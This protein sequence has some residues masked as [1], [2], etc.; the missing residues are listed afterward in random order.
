MPKKYFPSHDG[1][2]APLRLQVKGKVRFEEVDAV[3][4]VWHG[5]YSTYFEDARTVLGDKYGVGYMDFLRNET[6]V[7][8]KRLHIDYSIPLVYKE[9]MTIEA[10]MHWSEA[11][12]INYEF[13][14]KNSEG[15]VTTTGYTIQMM[16]DPNKK[17]R[18][19]PPPFYKKFLER[20]KAGELEI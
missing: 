1:Q 3:G 15:Q 20:W 18:M 5:R 9:E 6:L 17:I 11:A 2:P 4:I 10:I 7:P 8:I 13:I 19:I 14:I 12:R 16:L